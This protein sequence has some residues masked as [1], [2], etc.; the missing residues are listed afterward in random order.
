MI[1][2]YRATA[3]LDDPMGNRIAKEFAEQIVGGLGTNYDKY[4]RAWLEINAKYE[5]TRTA[6]AID[7]KGYWYINH[8][9][10]TKPGQ[11]VN[12]EAYGYD[13][14]KPDNSVLGP[15]KIP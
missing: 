11:P 9:P 8:P 10:K 3:P 6:A 15:F 12:P 2:G 5:S 1:L 7:N 14:T 4:A 13:S